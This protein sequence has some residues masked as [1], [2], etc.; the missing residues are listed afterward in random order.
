MLEFTLG[1]AWFRWSRL[2]TASRRLAIASMCLAAIAG[3]LIGMAAKPVN[4]RFG[5][6][7]TPHTTVLA[8]AG[9]AMAVLSAWL[10][11]RFSLRQDEMFNR[12]QNWAIGMS[13]AWTCVVL[14]VWSVLASVSL[15]MPMPSAAPAM[16]FAGTLLIFWFVAVRKWAY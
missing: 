5:F 8:V 9:I 6:D 1:G 14:T 16:L 4:A 10:W 11:Y 12:V 2:D 7:V 15:A 3:H 13:G